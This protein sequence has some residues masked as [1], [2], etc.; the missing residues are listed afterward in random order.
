MTDVEHQP[1]DSAGAGT[2][3]APEPIDHRT[4]WWK[5]DE[6][7]LVLVPLIVAIVVLSLYTNSRNDVFISWTNAENIL[8][9]T[10][11][12]G[13]IA[14]GQTYLIAAGQLDL[15]VGSL[16][17]F[18]AVI[19]ATMIRDGS[20]EATAV[21]AVLVVG[22]LIGLIWGLIVTRLRVP[23]FIL[24]LGGLSVL[25]SLAL[26][27]AGDV[28]VPA[29][30]RFGW[31][32]REELLGIRMPIVMFLAIAIVSA[33][34]LRYTRFGRHVFATGSSE[35]AAYLAGLPTQRT[36][37]LVFVINSTLC[38]F[39]GLIL[40]ARIGAGDPRAG[41][42]LELR[43]IAAVVLGGATLAG[44]RGSAFGTWLGVILLGVVG[45]SLTFLDV[46]ASYTDL[47]FGGVLIFAVV[48][49]AV[50]ELRRESSGGLIT[51]LGLDRLTRRPA[52]P[53]NAKP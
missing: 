31:L 41:E 8:L 22:A 4:P 47:V 21:V 36:K 9:Q 7:Q 35:E 50:N 43:A 17:S 44:G 10:A 13:I 51:A 32:N 26:V 15:S 49:T 33:L 45:S 11:V 14:I 30:D 2:G 6:R 5:L 23:P 52:P 39:A 46:D 12:L 25:Q 29:R 3:A 38:A 28:P 16:A 53:P 34:V 18:S 19:G 42:G 48:L 40:M 1:T 20:S 27:R 37:L 24:T